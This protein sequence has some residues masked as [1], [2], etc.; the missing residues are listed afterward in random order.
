MPSFSVPAATSELSSAFSM[1]LPYHSQ[2]PSLL[3]LVFSMQMF[4][5]EVSNPFGVL[6]SL[7]ELENPVD[8]LL[9]VMSTQKNGGCAISKVCWESFPSYYLY[10]KHTNSSSCSLSLP[11]S[12]KVTYPRKCDTCLSTYFNK[13]S[14]SNHKRSCIEKSKLSDVINDSCSVTNNSPSSKLALS[15]PV[16]ACEICFKTFSSKFSLN[17]HEEKCSSPAEPLYP[18]M[19]EKCSR[20]FKIRKSF[21]KHIKN[22]STNTNSVIHY[23]PFPS[24]TNSFTYLSNFNKHML[25]NHQLDEVK[26]FAFD[27]VSSFQIWL[28]QESASTFCSFRK[29]SGTRKEHSKSFHYY[30]CTFF[31]Q[32]RSLEVPRKTTRKYSKGTIPA[33]INCPVRICA[34]ELSDK[35]EVTYYCDHNH[36][37]G[38]ENLKYL[39]LKQSTR[40]IIKTYLSFSVPIQKVQK[41][42]R[43]ELGSQDERNFFPI[44][45][46]FVSRK[47]IQAYLRSLEN[48]M[49][50]KD[51]LT[52]VVSI[53]E[54]LRKEN[55]DPILIFKLQNNL[56]LFMALLIWIFLPTCQ[57]SFALCFQTE[58]Q[59][60]S[61][62][63]QV[64]C[65]DSTYKTNQYDFY[66]INLIVP[67][68]YGKG[69]Q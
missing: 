37:T 67:D 28:E 12:G 40:D 1:P 51:N 46:V 68:K 65:I 6:E 56:Q 17:C 18:R 66:F 22:C 59:R 5:I 61:N 21:Y 52:S 19:C 27:S 20:F 25:S 15:F 24:C 16:Y 10:K 4:N 2:R 36:Y 32:S 8:N 34:C 57:T 48:S 53:A 64:L 43:G 69:C 41:M 3:Q 42:L 14:F 54:C 47:V 29:Y 45:E 35:V 60:V 44:K 30:C 39:W 38:V 11:M 26:Q 31:D 58:H 50:P 23:C 13:S 33:H 55:Y 9:K 63:D 49:F 7:S 62:S